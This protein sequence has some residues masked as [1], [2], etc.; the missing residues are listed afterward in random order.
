MPDEQFTELRAAHEAANQGLNW[1][2]MAEAARVR[3][4]YHR[5]CDAH[6]PFLFAALDQARAERDERTLV[7]SRAQEALR[8][9]LNGLPA[10]DAV[11]A[12]YGNAD[13]ARA[14]LAARDNC[15]RALGAAEW[16]EA[17]NERLDTMNRADVEAEVV[18]L[19]KGGE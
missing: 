14:W 8:Y 9:V 16:L 12:A 1:Q 3:P 19:R 13:S 2:E 17:N 7:A 5:L 15:M 4:E 11:W 18:K 6:L 10:T